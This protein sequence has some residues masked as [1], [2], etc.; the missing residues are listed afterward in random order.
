MA[1][2]GLAFADN[3]RAYVKLHGAA[4][5]RARRGDIFTFDVANVFR[6]GIR[7]AFL[8]SEGRHMRRTIREDDFVRETTLHVNDIYP[9]DIPMTTMPPTLLRLLPPLP[10]PLAYR[11]IGDALVL[12]DVNTNAIVDFIPDA[13]PGLR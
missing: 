9:D 4:R 12:Q 10:E 7:D 3:L 8:G 11:I 1:R 13:I 6:E 2:F 5:P